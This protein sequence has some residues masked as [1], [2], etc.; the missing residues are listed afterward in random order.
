METSAGSKGRLQSIGSV[1]HNWITGDVMAQQPPLPGI[2]EAS[3]DMGH[4]RRASI[5]PSAPSNAWREQTRPLALPIQGYGR[6]PDQRPAKPLSYSGPD[7]HV[8]YIPRFAS[9]PSS[10][11]AFTPP[12]LT[13]ESTASTLQSSVSSGSHDPRIPQ[14][15][16]YGPRTPLEDPLRNFP[17][18]PIPSIYANAKLP[19]SFE[20]QQ[21]P[22]MRHASLSP[23]TSQ[24]VAYQPGPSEHNLA[25]GREIANVVI[26]AA[27]YQGGSVAQQRG[28]IFPVNRFPPVTQHNRPPQLF[29]HKSSADDI[30][31]LDPIRALIDA[32]EII[33]S[34]GHQLQQKQ[35]QH[36]SD[37]QSHH[38]QQRQ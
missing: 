33:N 27:D 26:A 15:H 19:V 35:S 9:Q 4:V 22:P 23:S 32:G 12:L 16:Y 13:S 11:G 7:S 31:P 34:Q 10:A 8:P 3:G 21:L 24:N 14:S 18:L 20:G 36:L 25:S 2:S 29:R 30:G 38:H 28:S 6:Q 5:I 37:Q 17:S 1:P